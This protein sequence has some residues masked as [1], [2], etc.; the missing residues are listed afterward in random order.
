MNAEEIVSH[1]EKFGTDEQRLLVEK[2][3][4]P[5][6]EWEWEDCPHCQKTDKLNDEAVGFL[7]KAA[8]AIDDAIEK[9]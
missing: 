8:D 4:N 5:P 7:R 9:L 6:E 1:I 2:L 3:W